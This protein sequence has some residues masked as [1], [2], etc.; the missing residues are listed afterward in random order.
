MISYQSV[1]EIIATQT[2][3][4]KNDLESTFFYKFKVRTPTYLA[5]VAVYRLVLTIY[6]LFDIYSVQTEFLNDT[7]TLISK[8]NSLSFKDPLSTSVSS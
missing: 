1:L 3:V 7:A 5:W 2:S 6:N 8:T 4:E